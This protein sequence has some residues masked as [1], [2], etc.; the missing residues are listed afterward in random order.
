VSF[1]GKSDTT[2]KHF[3]VV[4]H[5]GLCTNSP[6]STMDPATSILTIIHEALKIAKYI[7]DVHEGHKE[8]KQLSQE[9]IAVYQL[10]LGI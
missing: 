8:R 4:Q 1:T 5:I 3:V 2:T 10:F 7:E 6:L 9:M